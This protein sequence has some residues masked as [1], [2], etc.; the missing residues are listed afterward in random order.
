MRYFHFD[1]TDVGWSD[2]VG[3][4]APANLETKV[5]SGCIT[6][7]RSVDRISIE[8]GVICDFAQ[9]KCFL[10]NIEVNVKMGYK[11]DIFLLHL[12]N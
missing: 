1:G 10:S 12:S 2:D 7:Q 11:K 8:D 4:W 3:K 5:D 9:L 6:R